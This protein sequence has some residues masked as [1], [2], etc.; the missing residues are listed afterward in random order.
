[1]HYELH[2]NIALQR[3]VTLSQAEKIQAA[4][5]ENAELKK[6]LAKAQGWFLAT[7]TINSS[8]DC[9]IDFNLTLNRC[10]FFPRHSFVSTREPA[11]L[12]SS[13]RDE[14]CRGGTKTGAG[15]KATGG[16]EL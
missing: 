4:K 10:I 2:K 12:L 1:L 3:H 16:E 7:L 13:S 9:Q 15:G 8:S 11:L 5:E 6:Q 14:A